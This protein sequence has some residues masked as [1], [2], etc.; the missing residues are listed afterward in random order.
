M[1]RRR[2]AHEHPALRPAGPGVGWSV[3]LLVLL[4]LL[5][6]A[7]GCGGGGP[8]V[9]PAPTRVRWTFLA[10]PA[11]YYGS[12]ALS[13]DGRTV[14]VGTSLWISAPMSA[15]HA[16]TALDA[17]TGSARWSYPLRAREVRSTPAVGPDGSISFVVE[18]RTGA[19]AS[20]AL[21][22]I[23]SAGNLLWER[24]VNPTGVTLEVGQ[25]APA[26]AGDGTIYVAGD[27]LYAFRPDGSPRWTALAPTGEAWKN[28]PVIGRD[29]T[30][31]FVTHNVPLTALDPDTGAVRWQR[32]LGVD[33]HCLASPAI[34]ADGTLYVATQ[35]GLV[36]AVSAA[37]DLRW[38]FD[39]ASAG[40][41]GYLRSSPAV[42]ADGAI[43][44]GLNGGSP[45][46]ALFALTPGGAVRWIFQPG[47]LPAD[48]P[49]DHFDV[50]SSPAIGS[51]G[52]VYFGQE[53]GRVYALDPSGGAV[54][55]MQAT[56]SGI[57]W[58]SPAL[59]ADGLLYICDLSGTCYAISTDSRGTKATAP[60]PK[61]RGDAQNTG[62]QP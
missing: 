28:A 43:Y 25:S 48:V 9:P 37:G 12:P 18:Q 54:R 38:Q 30:V 7:A 2:V 39:I 32:S 8:G 51:D 62:R 29:G 55:W 21:L 46:S 49:R 44:F 45:S 15:A 3:R 53:F 17:A 26:I 22:H 27:R 20:D 16:F 19:S 5:A 47:D 41:T 6:V 23:S 1:D 35:P 11:V 31:Y 40:F 56:R 61:F 60:W 58:P 59:A 10:A 33:D 36:Y 13:T 34:G 42:D 57:T 52:T 14:Y 50:Y 24:D 4:V